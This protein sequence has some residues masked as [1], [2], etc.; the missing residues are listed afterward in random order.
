MADQPEKVKGSWCPRHGFIDPG[1]NDY[2][3]AVHRN[4]PGL[5][6]VEMLGGTCGCTLSD[7]EALIVPEG[8]VGVVLDFEAIEKCASEGCNNPASHFVLLRS[9]KRF[10]AAYCPGCTATLQLA[11]SKVWPI[12]VPDA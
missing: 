11:D 8:S 3:G 6:P 2:W 10:L 12:T 5:C 1:G 4:H 9:P 7:A